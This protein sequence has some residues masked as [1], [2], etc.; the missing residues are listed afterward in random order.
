MVDFHYI[1]FLLTEYLV[2]FTATCEWKAQENHRTEYEA[3]IANA[4]KCFIN[5]KKTCVKIV[6]VKAK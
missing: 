4:Y 2:L 3:A 5:C 6:S 1:A